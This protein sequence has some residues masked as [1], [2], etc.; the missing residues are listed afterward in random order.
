QKPKHIL[1]FDRAMPFGIKCAVELGRIF[2]KLFQ[3]LLMR[4]VSRSAPGRALKLELATRSS[5]APL[6]LLLINN[7]LIDCCDSGHPLAQFGIE[8]RDSVVLRRKSFY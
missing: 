8:V 3:H 2:G 1:S 4:L 7:P 6:R 5:V